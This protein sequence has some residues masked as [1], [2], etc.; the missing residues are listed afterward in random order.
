MINHCY[1]VVVTGAMGQLG[2]DVVKQ[3]LKKEY[4]VFATDIEDMDIL[5]EP[6]VKKFFSAANPDVIVHCAAYTNVDRAE[7]EKEKCYR[8]NVEGTWNVA[9]AAVEHNAE[10]VYIS[11]DYVFDGKKETAYLESDTPSPLNYYGFTKLRGEQIV[12][13]LTKKHFIL[14]TSCL[15]GQHGDNFVVKVLKQAKSADEIFVVN[16]QFSS[17]TY[18][19]DLAN[20]VPDLIASEQYGVYHG[21]NQGVCSRFELAS[22]IVE[23][24]DLETVITPVLSSQYPSKAIR[25]SNSYLGSEMLEHNGFCLLPHWRESLTMFLKLVA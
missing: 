5:D 15:Y 18:T 7:D 23:Q 17:P 14:R 8:V 13:S 16:D 1:R 3:L 20:L 19:V 6:G 24:I 4:E 21:A 12:T 2:Q 11:S 22:S 10:F 9:S 25:P